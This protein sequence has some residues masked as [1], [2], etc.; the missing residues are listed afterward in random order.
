MFYEECKTEWYQGDIVSSLPFVVTDL[1]HTNRTKALKLFDKPA[2]ITSQTCDLQR[3]PFIQ[4]CPIHDFGHLKAELIAGGKSEQGAQSFIDSV[5][6]KN[7]N[8]YFY[9][10]EDEGRGISEGYADLNFVTTVS[11][12][13][14]LQL[15][16]VC[17]LSDY[18]RQQLAYFVG[19]L[20]LRPH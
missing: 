18:A 16:R 5:R 17:T 6:N 1:T 20:Y 9:I 12:T 19:N 8:Y 2:L 3:R 10:P 7:V 11:R 15:S 14:L 4:V 13:Q